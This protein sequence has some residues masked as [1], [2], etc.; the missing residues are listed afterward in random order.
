MFTLP[1]FGTVI[2]NFAGVYKFV[3]I[4]APSGYKPNS[5]PVS[6]FFAHDDSFLFQKKS[7]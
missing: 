5:S 2:Y 7:F 1:F 6:V 4:V 3:L